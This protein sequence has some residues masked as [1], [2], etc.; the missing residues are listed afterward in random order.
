VVGVL[1]EELVATGGR[2]GARRAFEL[3]HFAVLQVA[4]GIGRD[5]RTGELV[6]VFRDHLV[7]EHR[8]D[9]LGLDGVD[10]L[11]IGHRRGTGRAAGV[12]DRVDRRGVG[13][14]ARVRRRLAHGIAA[15]AAGAVGFLR[16]VLVFGGGLV[17]GVG[18]GRG[19]VRLGLAAVAVLRLGLTAVA[20]RRLGLTAVAVRR[21]G[22]TAVAVRRLGLT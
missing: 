19:F 7:G 11:G 16:R 21:L 13:R 22:L 6:A 3:G 4:A 2:G 9:A 8:V 15:G 20:V 17:F 1:G 12:L 10:D 14:E 5:A 18:L